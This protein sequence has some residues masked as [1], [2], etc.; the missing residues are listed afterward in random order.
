[1]DATSE[2]MKK[3]EK[4]TVRDSKLICPHCNMETP[5]TAIRKDRRLEDGTIVYGL[6]KWEKHEFIPRE[7]DVFQ[8]RLYCIRYEDQNSNRYYTAPKEKDLKREEKVIELLKERFERWQEKGYIASSIIEEGDKTDEPIRTR[9]WVYWHQLFNPRQLLVHGLLMEIIDKEAK[10]KKEK[11]VGLLGSN[12]CCD[13]NSKLSIWNT[14]IGVETT[15]NT[16]S[17]QALNTLFNYGTRSLKHLG[18]SWFLNINYFKKSKREILKPLDARVIKDYNLFWLT[19]PLMQML[20]TT[21]SYLNFSLHGTRRC[22]LIYSQ[23]GMQT[24][25]GHWLSKEQ[26]KISIKA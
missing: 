5:I 7:E 3:A 19:D 21:M 10:T 9:G 23:N 25:K 2:E 11:V 8:E 16:F 22:Y 17:N 18:S 12:K 26:E 14:G 20:L 24:L 15:Q 6:R 13:W 1:M 4:G